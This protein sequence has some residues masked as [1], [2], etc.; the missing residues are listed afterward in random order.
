VVYGAHAPQVAAAAKAAGADAVLQ[1]PPLGTAH[2]VAATKDLLGDFEGDVVVLYADTPL[3]RSETVRGA[4]AAVEQGADVAVLGFDTPQPGAYGRLV[5]ENGALKR[6]VEAN[7][8]APD[9][10]KITLCN[11]GVLAAPARTLFALVAQVKNKNAKKEYYL[12]D[13]VA[14]AKRAEAVTGDAAEF[15]GVNSRAELM[16]AET[17]FQ[18]RMRR[19]AL[20]A[21]VTMIAPETVFF[22]HDTR[23][24]EDVTVEPYVVFGAGVEIAAGAIV[25]SFS[26]V[27]G[28]KIGPGA[29]V[30]P[31]A[32]LRPGAVLGENAKIG[33]FVE[34][35]NTTLGKD[36]KA[37]HLTYLGDAQ[38]GANANIGAGTITCNYD[39]FLKHRTVIGEGAFVGSNSALVA[40]VE[41]GARAYVGSGSVITGSVPPDAL[42]VARG[43]QSVI[44]NWAVRFRERMKMM[45]ADK[46]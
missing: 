28:A 20:E 17:A 37:N 1:D 2:A 33:N 19:A 12:T 30:G 10:L 32:R 5:V 38:I 25:H 26:H 40:P 36:A 9:E 24:A 16:E 13:I 42:G 35:K 29:S 39:G 14:I 46:P 3:V 18:A 21:G 22:T 41:I 11:S 44:P 6:I 43:R 23:L 15:A 4:F 7:D 34:V 8:A 45:K 31:F 27:E